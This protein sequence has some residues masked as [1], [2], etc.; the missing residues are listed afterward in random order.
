[1]EAAAIL[2]FALKDFL[3][4]GI[5]LGILLL[6]AVG[7]WEVSFANLSLASKL[8]TMAA[9]TLQLPLGQK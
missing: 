2:T 4:A 3:D 1:M 7:G 9:T 5:I 8:Q 6:N